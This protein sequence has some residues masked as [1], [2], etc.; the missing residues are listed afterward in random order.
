M[1]YSAATRAQIRAG[2]TPLWIIRH[3]RA[4]YVR[5]LIL[6]TPD[7][8]DRKAILRLQHDAR[9]KTRL[10]G[11]AYV[12]D[13]IVPL[14]HPL[15]CGLNVPWNMRVIPYAENA[16]RSNRWWQWTEDLFSFPQ[17]LRLW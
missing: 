8:V 1:N 2:R 15:V 13:H 5:N 9:R 17:Q 3:P 16:A 12:V 7:W 10:S 6:A 14:T 4:V 11:C